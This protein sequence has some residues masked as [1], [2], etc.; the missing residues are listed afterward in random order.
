MFASRLLVKER[1]KARQLT[2]ILSVA[3]HAAL[4]LGLWTYSFWKINK[5]QPKDDILTLR[6]GLPKLG[7]NQPAGAPAPF[8][9]RGAPA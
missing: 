2:V 5:L 9:M 1:S 3:A 8:V 7:D 4:A 6:V